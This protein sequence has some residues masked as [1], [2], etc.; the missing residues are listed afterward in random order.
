MDE[1]FKD[2]N[3]GLCAFL[4]KTPNSFFAVQNIKERLAAVGFRELQESKKWQLQAGGKY[5][6]SRNGSAL[7]AF[8]LPQAEYL[9]FQIYACHCDSP[10][11]KLKHNAEIVVDEKYVKL[12]VEKYGGMLLNTWLDRPLSLAGRVLCSVEG[13][14]EARLLN[15]E[16][17]L[18]V[19]PNLAIHMNKEANEG[20]KL[21][22]QTDMLP[23]LGGLTAKGGLQRLV[24]EGC[25]VSPEQLVD[26]ELFLYNRMPATTVGLEQEY[27]ASGRLDDLQCVFAGLEG[28]LAAEAGASVPLFCMLDN[29]EVGSGT[30]QGAGASFLKDVL[31]RINRGLGMAITK[32]I[33]D[34]MNGTIAV[35]SKLGVG[36]EFDVCLT[37]RIAGEKKAA[38]KPLPAQTKAEIEAA[39]QGKHILLVEDNK[40]NQEIAQTILTE[41][42]FVIDTADD[43][44]VA[45]EKLRQSAA[46]RYDLVLMD[47]QM[48]LMDGYEATRRIRALNTENAL[49]P[50]IAMTANAFDEDKEKALAAGMNG[51][52][53][54]PINICLLKKAIA[55]ALL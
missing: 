41:A 13:R 24:A 4:D 12:N 21:N 2:I 22:A 39:L 26:M 43:G 3:T 20:F 55:K 45:V 37:F 52:L 28:F 19:I 7:L 49:I 47:I 35:K 44:T 48:P 10:A 6:V 18:L 51:H 23:L 16:Q 25:G 8:V 34:M 27:V 30:K 15:I 36:T 9:G 14:L 50:I 17:D 11:F 46:G 5:Y 31:Q 53:A 54:K 38:A 29:E 32:K 42:G 40:L 33:V 1:V